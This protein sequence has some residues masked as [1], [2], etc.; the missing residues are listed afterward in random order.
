MN[1]QKIKEI[2]L[3]APC[4]MYCGACRHYLAKS[5]GLLK[6]RNL[7]HGCEGCRIRNKNCAWIKKDCALL[8]KK[9]IDFCFECKDF[10]CINLKKLNQRY[11][12]DY[13]ESLVNNLLRIKEIGVKQWFNEQE[14]KWRCPK[15]G[16]NVCVHDKECYDCGYKTNQSQK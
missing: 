10:S 2:N 6:E 3:A 14:D 12:H 1:N 7:K 15:C 16:G 13:S 8:R 11:S 9:E 4:G 5:K